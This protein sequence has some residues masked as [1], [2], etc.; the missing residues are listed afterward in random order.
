MV[1]LPILAGKVL[2]PEVWKQQTLMSPFSSRKGNTNRQ[3]FLPK[4]F[5]SWGLCLR[6]R[7][8][9]P[10]HLFFLFF[11]SF[12]SVFNGFNCWRLDYCFSRAFHCRMLSPMAQASDGPSPSSVLDSWLWHY[13]VFLAIIPSSGYRAFGASFLVLAPPGARFF[14]RRLT[15]AKTYSGIRLMMQFISGLSQISLRCAFM[16]LSLPETWCMKTI[17]L[18]LL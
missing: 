1:L 4:G 18:L 7:I 11:L 3:Y 14:H 5:G 9:S 12:F 10:S 6:S 17:L 16:I 2:L 15:S 8:I 13:S